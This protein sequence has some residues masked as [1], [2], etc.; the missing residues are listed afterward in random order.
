LFVQVVVTDYPDADLIENLTHNINLNT[1]LLSTPLNIIAEGYLW[2]AAITSLTAHLTEPPTTRTTTTP[3]PRFTLLLLA[4]L[5]FNHSEH[6][7]LL[8]TVALSLARTKEA[9]ALIF[10]TPYRPWLFTADLNFIEL[11]SGKKIIVNDT[12][13]SAE[14]STENYDMNEGLDT[15]DKAKQGADGDTGIGKFAVKKILETKMEKVMFEEDRGD[16]G[17]RRTVFGFEMRWA[18]LV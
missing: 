8:R 7:R 2:G 6:K 5:L 10:F 13:T 4:D 1:R 11:A 17:L 9:R 16:E 12:R 18:D 14:L 15:E 3:S